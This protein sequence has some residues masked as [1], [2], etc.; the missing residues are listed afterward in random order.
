MSEHTTVLPE[1][2]PRPPQRASLGVVAILASVVVVV[3]VVTG[4]FA[5]WRWFSGAGPRPA[6]VLPASTFALVPVD[7]DPSGGQKVEAIKTL[8][9]FPEFRDKVGLKP[10]SDPL[11]RLFD[12]MQ[13]DGTCKNLD[14]E[15]DVKSW[16]G[17]RVGVGGV[18]L[19]GKPRPVVALQVSDAANAKTGF[20][21]LAK[22][23]ELTD[24]GWTLTDDYIVISDSN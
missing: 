12:A 6:E 22:C 19:D 23:L 14:Y 15:R 17:Q 7:L 13:D 8:R 21:R 18:E 20:P 3:L 9:K 1:H 4:G 16:I 5:A 11:K 24:Y 10:D 2:E